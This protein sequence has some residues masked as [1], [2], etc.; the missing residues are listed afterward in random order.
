MQEHADDAQVEIFRAKAR[1]STSEHKVRSVRQPQ[2]GHLHIKKVSGGA[3][4]LQHV[5]FRM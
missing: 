4:A 5:T 1:E 3:R 2:H